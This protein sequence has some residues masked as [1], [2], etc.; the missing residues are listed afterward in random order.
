MKSAGSGPLEEKTKSDNP[1]QV[2]SRRVVASDGEGQRVV[3]N[4]TQV[5]SRRVVASDGEGQRVVVVGLGFVGLTLALALARR[6]LDV[7]G[8]DTNPETLRLLRQRKAPFHENGIQECIE[9]LV[10]RRLIVCD[11]LEEAQGDAYIVAV[12]TPLEED[13]RT[14]ALGG[15]RAVC[16]QVGHVLQEGNLVVLRSTVPV[17]TSREVALPVI[18]EASGLRCGRGFRL[19]F[20]PERTAEGRALH[21]LATNPQIVG[22]HTKPATE[23][24]MRLFENLSEAVIDVGSL[25]AAELS[26]LIDNSYRDHVFAY[27][28]MLAP[29]TER[30]GLDLHRIVDAVNF[31]YERNRVPRPSPGVG[32][33]CLS[34]DPLLLASVYERHGLST[35]MIEEVRR[36]NTRGP[37][38][39]CDKLLRLLDAAGKQASMARVSLV[40]L[41]FKGE[42]ETSDLRG[43]TSLALLAQLPEIGQ[44]RGYDPVVPAE[45]IAGLGLLPV[46]LEEAFEDADALLVL[47]NHAS[48]REWKLPTL[49]DR[50][51]KPAVFIDCWHLFEPTVIKG[52]ER[53][54]YGGVG[55]D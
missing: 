41:A 4:P 10:G 14:P 21:E 35:Q 8:V 3:D 27:A 12:G 33:P 9:D 16:S 1:T 25:E 11:S 6:G 32:G 28:N 38:L 13:G 44:L 20:A 7:R 52:V 51:R 47:N 2:D 54:L 5:D 34:K 36:I 22:G 43:S 15:L 40:G 55:N 53:I 17:G 23:S 45:A 50:M 18:E 30:L 24:A 42:P 46:S 29:L 39:V 26:K 19:A 49:L 31:S 37:G 48:Y